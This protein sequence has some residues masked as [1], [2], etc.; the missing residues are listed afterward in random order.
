MTETLEVLTPD[1]AAGLAERVAA[2]NAHAAT[3]PVDTPC[4][5]CSRYACKRCGTV[6]HGWEP[7][8]LEPKARPVC[9]ACSRAAY[10]AA[11]LRA[12]RE[13]LPARFAWASFGA[14]ELLARC[15]G[16]HVQT[17]RQ[18]LAAPRVVL[19]GQAGGGKT[20]LAVAMLRAV[21]EE[22][23]RRSLTERGSCRFA[24]A[25]AL[26]KARGQHPLGQGEAPLVA[27]ALRADTLVIDDLGSELDRFGTAVGEVLYE[28]HNEDRATWVTTWMTPAEASTRY[29]GGIARRIFEDAVVIRLGKTG[30]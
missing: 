21:I 26:N 6:V 3:C 22:S 17:A 29:G 23:K 9:D 5:R 30:P 12:A 7:D 28:R 1:F 24:S 13:S 2:H 11:T 25:Y 19:V 4:E 16:L 20:S 14:P 8:Y 18:A 10:E 15:G 27:D